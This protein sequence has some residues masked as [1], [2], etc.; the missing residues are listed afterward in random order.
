MAVAARR[1]AAPALAQGP[2]WLS[3]GPQQGTLLAVAA[4][5]AAAGTLY[6]A[7]GYGFVFRSTD[8]AVTWNRRGRVVSGQD[9][10]LSLIV[11]P[12]SS[13]VAYAGTT[14]GLFRTADGGLSWSA[15]AGAGSPIYAFA[16]A[17]SAPRTLYAAS[18][19]AQPLRSDDGGATWSAMGGSSAPPP[20]ASALSVDPLDPRRVYWGSSQGLWRTTDG[21]AT[22]MQIDASDPAPRGFVSQVVLAANQTVYALSYEAG[23]STLFRSGDG[24]DTWQQDVEPPSCTPTDL[25]R[26]AAGFLYVYC[27]EGGV[28]R[29]PEGGSW[30][31]TASLLP[32]LDPAHLIGSVVTG[33]VA[34]G[35]ADVVY[36]SLGRQG[37]LRSTLG[38]RT[39]LM[40]D[41]GLAAETV[42]QVLPLPGRL[43]LALT[44]ADANDPLAAGELFLSLDAGATWMRLELD[45][46]GAQA[47]PGLVQVA[48]D[49]ATGTLYTRRQNGALARSSDL[50]ATWRP[51]DA[52]LPATVFDVAVD[53]TRGGH[54]FAATASSHP[55]AAAAS[56]ATFTLFPSEDGGGSW[57]FASAIGEPQ[58]PAG[59]SVRID[60]QNPS[61]VYL[62]G[63]QLHRSLD[64]G[65]TFATLALPAAPTAFALDP[66]ASGILYA[67]VAAGGGAALW[68]SLDH[69]TSWTA[70]GRGLPAGTQ[71]QQLAV[72]PTASQTVY[73]GTSRGVFVSDD[74]GASFRPLRNGIR[75]LK[76]LSLA[77]TPGTVWIGTEGAGAFALTPGGAPATPPFLRGSRRDRR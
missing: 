76:V 63:G 24:G 29:R 20:P 48:W 55:C 19:G 17:P 45:A 62:V 6:A 65:T 54:L 27:F 33:L 1:A 52:Q 13:D 64:G 44:H 61:T 42:T 53:P 66:Q 47:I 67:G 5:P 75:G 34:D 60:P 70:V 2:P 9:A 3:L 73:A 31:R 43:L 58:P 59:A 49:P 23:G 46:Q 26:T 71:V 4:A 77:V 14:A 16:I 35:G 12:T 32:F 21:G 18:S 8:G 25:A 51:A 69:G 15:L 68:K 22:W 50:G 11:D 57:A 39:F 41:A 7:N 37:L 10:V 56:C 72:D 74:G 40:A 38:G 28:L 30:R 36:S